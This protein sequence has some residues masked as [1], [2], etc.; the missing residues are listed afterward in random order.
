MCKRKGCKNLAIFYHISDRNNPQ[1]DFHGTGLLGIFITLCSHVEI[2]G[3]IR[4][5]IRT[6]Y[7]KSDE[8]FCTYF[9]NICA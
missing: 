6:L 5:R 9:E 2:L 7:V 8:Y 3:K 1:S 4:E